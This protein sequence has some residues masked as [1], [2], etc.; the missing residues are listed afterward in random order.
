MRACRK[1]A[2]TTGKEE[3]PSRVVSVHYDEILKEIRKKL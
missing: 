3:V 1:R 2:T